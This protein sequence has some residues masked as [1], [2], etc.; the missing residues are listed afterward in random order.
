VLVQHPILDG[1]AGQDPGEGDGVV[2]APAVLA[3]D[4]VQ[5]DVPLGVALAGVV[6]VQA[7]RRGLRLADRVEGERPNA[8]LAALR[9]PPAVPGQPGLAVDGP[10]EAVAVQEHEPFGVA[11]VGEGQVE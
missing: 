5:Q 10:P 6:V 2:D 4:R 7:D 9:P 3:A 1:D 8:V 11:G